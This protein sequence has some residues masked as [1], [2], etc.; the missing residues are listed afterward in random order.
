MC[1]VEVV[2]EAISRDSVKEDCFNE[3][4]ISLNRMIR[5]DLYA[6]KKMIKCISSK[7]KAQL[8]DKCLFSNMIDDLK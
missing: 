3:E 6:F 4:E 8:S 2:N 1:K 5:N 7:F